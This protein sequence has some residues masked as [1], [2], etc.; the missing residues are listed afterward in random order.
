MTPEM[1]RLMDVLVKYR[2]SLPVGALVE[3][4]LFDE[5]APGMSLAEM[6]QVAEQGGRVRWNHSGIVEQVTV[7]TTNPTG[8]VAKGYYTK[9]HYMSPKPV[10]YCTPYQEPGAFLPPVG[11]PKRV[12]MN[13]LRKPV[14]FSSGG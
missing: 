2:V 3:L 13:L 9:P 8:F 4:G 12:V 1:R 11:D 7:S 10:Y 14:R 5:R 6:R